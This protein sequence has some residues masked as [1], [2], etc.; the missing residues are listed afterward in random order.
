LEPAGIGAGF[1]DAAVA[2]AKRRSE[3][4]TDATAEDKPFRDWEW[5]MDVSFIFTSLW[6]ASQRGAG[7]PGLT[8]V[9]KDRRDLRRRRR[10]L[11]AEA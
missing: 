3:Q 6:L 1:A 8:C 9:W 10:R 7:V 5:R 11:V 4:K 2:A